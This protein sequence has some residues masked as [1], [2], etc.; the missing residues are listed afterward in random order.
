MAGGVTAAMKRLGRPMTY[1]PALAKLVGLKES[2]FLCQL[3]YWT[4]R[5]KSERGE[6]WVYKSVEEAEEETGLSYKEQIRVRQRLVEQGLIEEE[7]ERDSHRLYFRVAVDRLDALADHLPDG[8][9]PKG[10]VASDHRE[11]ATLPKVSSHLPKGQ[12]DKGNRDY[13]ESNS[14]ITQGSDPSDS[15]PSDLHPLNYAARILEEFQLPQLPGTMRA[16]AAAVE[17]EIRAGKSPPA[18]YQ[19][20]VAGALDARDEG[21]LINAFFFADAKY[22][23]ENRRRDGESRR[24]AS[25]A[26]ARSERTKQNIIDGIAAEA[27]RRIGRLHP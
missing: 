14:E 8:H 5:G 22:R 4:P 24:Q 3:V 9:M 20:I 18:A 25:P 11:P 21:H 12:F 17:M 15:I 13:T 7:Y 16:A 6:G 26:A 23:V 10:E 19:F 1:Y 27:G 2:I